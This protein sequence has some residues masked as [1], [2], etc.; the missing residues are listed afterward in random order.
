MAGQKPPLNKMEETFKAIPFKDSMSSQE[1]TEMLQ[2]HHPQSI[3]YPTLTRSN[4]L[5]DKDPQKIDSLTSQVSDLHKEYVTLVKTYRSR[6][7]T[8]NMM[9]VN[10]QALEIIERPRT[11]SLSSEK[12][13]EKML[14]LPQPFINVNKLHNLDSS[15]NFQEEKVQEQ[16]RA[17][18]MLAPGK[19]PQESNNYKKACIAH[20]PSKI[21][22]ESGYHIYMKPE[23]SNDTSSSAILDHQQ[24]ILRDVQ[25]YHPVISTGGYYSVT[26][27]K[28]LLDVNTTSL[29]QPEL[30]V[31]QYEQEHSDM[32]FLQSAWSRATEAL[33]AGEVWKG[34]DSEQKAAFDKAII[35]RAQHKE[36]DSSSLRLQIDKFTAHI[37]FVIEALQ[38]I[39][40]SATMVDLKIIP[41]WAQTFNT[42][43]HQKCNMVMASQRNHNKYDLVGIRE[44]ETVR[45]AS[46]N[47][48]S[49]QCTQPDISNYRK[50]YP[51]RKDFTVQVTQQPMKHCCSDFAPKTS[52]NLHEKQ[53]T[54]IGEDCSSDLLSG[55]HMQ[56]NAHSA[57]A[58]NSNNIINYG[59]NGT[60]PQM[61]VE[62]E[63]L[64]DGSL[65]PN[66]NIRGPTRKIEN[67]PQTRL[68]TLWW[69]QPQSNAYQSRVL[70]TGQVS[71]VK[72]DKVSEFDTENNFPADKR[73]L[74]KDPSI[75]KLETDDGKQLVTENFPV[76][77][78]TLLEMAIK[79]PLPC[80]N[81]PVSVNGQLYQRVNLPTMFKYFNH[82]GFSD[83]NLLG[84]MT[85]SLE[86]MSIPIPFPV[87]AGAPKWL[88]D[89]CI[90]NGQVCHPLTHAPARSLLPLV[91][92]HL[93]HDARLPVVPTNSYKPFESDRRST[94]SIPQEMKMRSTSFVKEQMS[95]SSSAL[96]F[97]PFQY[98][99]AP[100]V[101]STPLSPEGQGMM[102]EAW[103][104]AQASK[105]FLKGRDELEEEKK[106]EC[107]RAGVSLTQDSMA[108]AASHD[109][110]FLVI[111]QEKLDALKIIDQNCQ[112]EIAP[113]IQG[114]NIDL[115]GGDAI[116][117]EASR[118]SE[119]KWYLERK[120]YLETLRETR[121]SR[122]NYEQNRLNEIRQN[123]ELHARRNDATCLD[124]REFKDY[125]DLTSPD[126]EEFQASIADAYCVYLAARTA[127]YAACT[128]LETAVAERKALWMENIHRMD[129][130]RFK[131]E[132]S[133][134]D[135]KF[136]ECQMEYNRRSGTFSAI[137][138]SS[139]QKYKNRE[140]F[141][142]RMELL[143][144]ACGDHITNS[145]SATFAADHDSVRV[146]LA[147]LKAYYTA[148]SAKSD[149]QPL[150]TI[151]DAWTDGHYG[152][153]KQ[154][155]HDQKQRNNSISSNDHITVEEHARGL[156]DG[157]DQSAFQPLIS[158][159]VKVSAHHDPRTLKANIP[160]KLPAVTGQYSNPGSRNF[161]S[162][163]STDRAEYMTMFKEWKPKPDHSDIMKAMIQG[164]AA[165][166]RHLAGQQP[167][168]FDHA[169]FQHLKKWGYSRPDNSINTADSS[170]SAKSALDL[171]SVNGQG[172]YDAEL[173]EKNVAVLKNR[174]DMLT[175]TSKAADTLATTIDKH[176]VMADKMD[177]DVIGITK[178]LAELDVATV[179]QSINIAD[180]AVVEA[181]K[182]DDI[183]T[184]Q[185][186]VNN[187]VNPISGTTG[188][189]EMNSIANLSLNELFISD[190]DRSE[191][192]TKDMMQ[193]SLVLDFPLS[194]PSTTVPVS[195]SAQEVDLDDDSDFQSDAS[196]VMA[197]DD[198][199]DDVAEASRP[200]ELESVEES[201]DVE[202]WEML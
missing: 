110:S 65:Y 119:R 64:I 139:Q 127:K 177:S 109:F 122:R 195:S 132:S 162:V 92:R 155:M 166:G 117:Q 36:L 2:Q 104:K 163:K 121:L 3:S 158:R 199:H 189:A 8:S 19:I 80:W 100:L 39:G 61:R 183:T 101:A 68:D 187:E 178:N 69:R 50:E 62:N 106:F 136:L 28:E 56:I 12:P 83:E 165:R 161:Y 9:Q 15:S 174:K 156:R 146:T 85:K 49:I 175:E 22:L 159:S 21:D 77:K 112:D 33:H 57:V 20:L 70:R 151:D 192:V 93:T 120:A 29:N 7:A 179:N 196:W 46:E 26:L 18:L 153:L 133:D 201:E 37:L 182:S 1:S 5:Q 188:N 91:S 144:R 81:H 53:A 87:L 170:A 190:T 129:N 135:K 82:L 143:T 51:S 125:R 74:E 134:A 17:S 103:K 128:K 123:K 114:T 107:D 180:K 41:G 145:V 131:K 89:Y 193:K 78:L 116:S 6:L 96:G 152:F 38:N 111:F 171:L 157:Y 10:Q 115:N 42:L 67:V 79:N 30:Q 4:N 141:E 150:R 181:T 197:S 76:E 184:A 172:Q 130:P 40:Y 94:A 35:Y 66:N 58:V 48:R 44:C 138:H 198:D 34:M 124:R 108:N 24:K 164:R 99:R 118:A 160:S 72:T 126:V 113:L 90:L 148:R 105:F 200:E 63:E 95:S 84:Q 88:Y 86:Q 27:N 185:Q 71:G 142:K 194:P 11:P 25:K 149:L 31:P 75:S 59:N 186:A 168:K 147:R 167:K 16:A 97:E 169:T 202:E 55:E 23:A 14:G 54:F 52:Q 173:V 73:I 13:L 45:G 32:I 98:P 191:I 154:P 140:A 43:S 102:I 137:K 60:T 47:V 176:T